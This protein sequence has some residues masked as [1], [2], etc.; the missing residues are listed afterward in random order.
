MDGDSCQVFPPFPSYK[1][2][3]PDCSFP[4]LAT[5]GPLAF[6]INWLSQ[7]LGHLQR[8]RVFVI[9]TPVIASSNKCIL[10]EIK[11][12]LRELGDTF[13]AFSSLLETRVQIGVC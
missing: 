12:V 10:E 6:R 1:Y 4:A 5:D 13:N 7:F 8:S 3:S 2:V 11:G 9:N